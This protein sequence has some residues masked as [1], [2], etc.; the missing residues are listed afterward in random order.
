L[1]PGERKWQTATV[2]KS[3]FG[4]ERFLQQSEPNFIK[5]FWVS[6]WSSMFFAFSWI[7]EGSTEKVLQYAT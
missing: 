5:P 3:L 1:T 4:H 6:Q 7:I 2:S